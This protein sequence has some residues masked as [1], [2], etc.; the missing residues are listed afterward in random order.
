MPDIL[1]AN[2]YELNLFL[3]SL[4]VLV[5]FFLIR[6]FATLEFVVCILFLGC[7]LPAAPGLQSAVYTE[8]K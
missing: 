4:E 2:G 6:H 5:T 1:V 8:R 7:I 3:H